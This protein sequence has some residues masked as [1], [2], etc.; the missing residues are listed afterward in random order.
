MTATHS[1]IFRG[2]V[3]ATSRPISGS[4]S[5][6][7][8]VGGTKAGTSPAAPDT[9]TA[10][11]RPCIIHSARHLPARLPAKLNGTVDL[12]EHFFPAQQLCAMLGMTRGTGAAPRRRTS[13]RS[14]LTQIRPRRRPTTGAPRR[15]D[16]LRARWL[17]AP[18][19]AHV[20]GRGF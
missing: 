12:G 20:R 19:A 16:T 9:A 17:P 10:P 7:F 1:D 8:A 4:R 6:R 3:V 2:S 5:V 13:R 18:G 15:T 14:G 11:P